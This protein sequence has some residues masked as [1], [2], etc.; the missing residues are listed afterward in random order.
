MNKGKKRTPGRERD[1]EKEEGKKKNGK[2]AANW[3][4]ERKDTTIRNNQKRRRRRRQRRR[5]ENGIRIKLIIFN[6]LTHAHTHKRIRHRWWEYIKLICFS[7]S[8][9]SA[10]YQWKL[11]YMKCV[12]RCWTRSCTHK[13]VLHVFSRPFPRFSWKAYTCACVH[14]L[15]TLYFP[16]FVTFTS[17]PPIWI[18]LTYYYMICVFSQRCT[19]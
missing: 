3:C 15:N 13:C 7:L 19:F 9:S 16:L 11:Q 14:H 1:R 5:E 10:Y 18:F 8:L 17:L 6:T 2:K 12:T 4:A